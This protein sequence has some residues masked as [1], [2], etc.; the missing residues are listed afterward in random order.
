[1]Q[2]HQFVG[3]DGGN[4]MLYSIVLFLKASGDLSVLFTLGSVRKNARRKVSQGSVTS[5]KIKFP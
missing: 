2:I 1:M 3:G 5:F 4:Q